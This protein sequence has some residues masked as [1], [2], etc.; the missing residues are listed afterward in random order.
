MT[1][2]ITSIG[3]MQTAK[4]IAALYALIGIIVGIVTLFVEVFSPPNVS[5]APTGLLVGIVGLI[6]IPILYAVVGFIAVAITVWI[7]NIVAKRAGGVEF[8]ATQVGPATL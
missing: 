3:I 5:G 4:T 2:R 6:A 1:L 8:T 7:Y